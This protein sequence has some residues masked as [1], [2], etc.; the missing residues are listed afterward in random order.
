MPAAV[1]LLS[2]AAALLAGGATRERAEL[3]PQLAF[4]LLETGDL[5]R[6]ADRGRD[7]RGGDRGRRDRPPALRRDHRAV[8]PARPQP[9]GLGGRGREGGDAGDR[10]LRRRRRRARA[11]E[12]VGAARAACTSSAPSSRAAEDAWERAAEHARRPGD[13]RDEL[14]SLAW[15]PLVVWA[16]PTPVDEGLRRCAEVLARAEGDKK[17]MA[18]ALVAQA[19]LT[20]DEGR[21][22]ERA[23]ARRAGQGA[24]RGDRADGLAGRA[25]RPVRGLGRAARR[26]PRPRR[27]RAARGAT[28][29]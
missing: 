17:V 16:G 7:D 11:G 18:S 27:A 3:L 13:R 5:D 12:G 24:A 19:V 29:G 2:R 15:V 25:G 14:E 28:S 26:R 9:R 1:N 10:R 22:E 20:A 6:L 21:V 4:A 23:T 8:G